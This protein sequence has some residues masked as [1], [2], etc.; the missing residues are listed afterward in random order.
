MARLRDPDLSHVIGISG[1]FEVSKDAAARAYAQYHEQPIAIAVVK[2]GEVLRIYKNA[3]FP[4][5]GV[6]NH[7]AVPR[8]SVYHRNAATRAGPPSGSD[9]T[10]DDLNACAHRV[11]QLLP[12][13]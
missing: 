10:D 3:K 12:P 6:Q 7:E 5:F 8:P 2:D 11:T 13:N 4:K 1:D 9:V